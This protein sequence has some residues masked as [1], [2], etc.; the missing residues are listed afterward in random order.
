MKIRS[1]LHLV[2]I[3]FLSACVSFQHSLSEENAARIKATKIINIVAQDELRP[4]IVNPDQQLAF[5]IG[6]MAAALAGKAIA[7]SKME[8]ALVSL[9]PIT[10]GT[11]D[12]DFRQLQRQHLSKALQAADW[13]KVQAITDRTSDI[14]HA[15]L[16]AAF[17][18]G[19]DDVIMT[20]YTRYL[21]SPSFSTVVIHSV[22]KIWSK[23]EKDPMYTGNFEYQSS[24]VTAEDEPAVALSKWSAKKQMAY[25][26]ALKEGLG[27]IFGMIAY[28]V[29]E[30]R[31]AADI[32]KDAVKLS[33]TTWEDD[34]GRIELDGKAVRQVG[35]RTWMRAANGVLVSLSR[36]S[37]M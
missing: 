12:M 2:P 1:V 7:N 37:P 21:I 3:L 16:G 36:T 8:A 4:A 28:E 23:A 10:E 5:V 19:K 29:G 35:D 25:R 20:L 11:R 27:E 30:R 24:P 22:V 13:L 33:Y 14:S 6:P 9:R 15:E 31:A 18:G 17:T 34:R 32:G 26:S